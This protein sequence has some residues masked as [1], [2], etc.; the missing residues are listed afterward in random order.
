MATITYKGTPVHTFGELPAQGS[1]APDFTLTKNDFTDVSLKDFAGKKKI[2]N[3][4]LS[5]DTGT[6]SASATRFEGEVEKLGNTVVLT[7]SRDLPYASRRF[8]EAAGVSSVLTLSALRDES[9]GKDYGVLMIDGPRAGL[10]SRAIV[11]LNEED[12]VVYTEQVP[13]IAQEPD[14]EKALAAVS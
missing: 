5:L 14:Y 12:E 6:C 7:V 2:I 10:L 13:E 4:V 8:C 11:V 3:I 1:K 9:F